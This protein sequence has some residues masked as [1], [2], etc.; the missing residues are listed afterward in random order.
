MSGGLAKRVWRDEVVDSQSA[1]PRMADPES[2][3]TEEF[4]SLEQVALL[5]RH[6]SRIGASRIP[7]EKGSEDWA[8]S[9]RLE[10]PR[11]ASAKV[12]HKGKW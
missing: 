12:A 3:S 11:S 10:Y 9:A 6:R 2:K 7:G 1:A 4:E 5:W 8:S